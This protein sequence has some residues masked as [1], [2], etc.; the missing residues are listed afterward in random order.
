MSTINSSSQTRMG[1]RKNE[2]ERNNKCCRDRTDVDSVYG[3]GIAQTALLIF[4][5]K[6]TQAIK[7]FLEDLWK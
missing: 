7:L 4:E 6:I 2:R 3:D 1:M 5:S